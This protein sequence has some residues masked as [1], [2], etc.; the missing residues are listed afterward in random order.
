M[1]PLRVVLRWARE[2]GGPWGEETCYLSALGG[3]LAVLQWAREHHCVNLSRG[4][5]QRAPCCA[6]VGAGARLPVPGTPQHC[7]APQQPSERYN[8]QTL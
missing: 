8:S 2:H 3:H 6:A 5:R 7:E 4:R 1:L